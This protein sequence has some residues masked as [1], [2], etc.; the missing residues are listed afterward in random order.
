[1]SVLIIEKEKKIIGMQAKQG[2]RLG[3]GTMCLTI[4][5]STFYLEWQAFK[6]H[7]SLFFFFT[8]L[9]ISISR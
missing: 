7:F 3:G 2:E 4:C 6:A 1:M 8:Y 5:Y 9:V